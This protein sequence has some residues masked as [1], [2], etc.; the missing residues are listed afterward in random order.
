MTFEERKKAAKAMAA[1]AKM[2]GR[3]LDQDTLS[4]ILDKLADLSFDDF[5]MA[6]V[7]YSDDPRNKTFPVPAQLKAIVLQRKDPR[8][9]AIEASARIVSAVS[10][11]GWTNP[12]SAKQYI[13]ELGWRC[14]QMIGG[15]QYVC[16]NLGVNINVSTFQAQMRD[17][18]EA[19]FTRSANGFGDQPPELPESTK[20]YVKQNLNAAPE[21]AKKLLN[22]VFG[23]ESE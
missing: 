17:L 11:C 23:F 8:T 16:E 20:E 5:M 2:Y 21:S 3:D 7:V 4:L 12:N 10:S 13:G 19:S 15:W 6:I 1:F 18:A 22:Q 14:V 9:E